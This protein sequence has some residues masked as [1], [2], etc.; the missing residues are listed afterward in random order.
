MKSDKLME[1]IMPVVDGMQKNIYVSSITNGMMGTMGVMMASA[2]FQLIYSFPITPWTNFL[3]SIGL[4]SLLTTVVNICNLTAIFMVFNIGRTLGEK[5]GVDGIQTGLASLLCFLIITPLEEVAGDFGSTI[6]IN[7]SWLGAQGIFTAMIVALIAPTLYAF[8]INHNIVIKL[9]AAVPEFVSKNL[10]GIPSALATVVP[11]V[12]IRGIF[13][14]TAWGSFTSFIY[15]MIQ[16]PLSGLGN[17]LP[18]HLAAVAICCFLWWCGVH[19]TLVVLGA[20]MA[21]WSTATI[22]NL[23]AFNAGEPIPFLLSS[24]TFF[25]IL[26]FT[27]GPGCLFGLYVNMAF[28]S[29]SERFKAQGKLSLVPGFFNIIEPTVFGVPVVLNPVLLVPFVGLPVVCYILY[30]VLASIGIIGVPAVNLTV[31]VLPGPIAGFLLGGGISLGIFMLAILALSV[32]VYYPFFKVLD[33][34][35]LKEEQALAAQKS[36]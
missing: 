12:A 29:K 28:F 31:M 2:I 26:Q 7:T 1:K 34:Q 11:F 9:P 20:A 24:V 36:K 32:V 6:Y 27:G 25:L 3:Q 23:T 30:Y 21:V 18:A 16:T 17:S 8:C 4:Y 33:N 13:E 22:Q 5:K 19:G 10:S 14:M 15:S 35:A